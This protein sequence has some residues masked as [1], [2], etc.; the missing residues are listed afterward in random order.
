MDS[1]FLYTLITATG[2]IYFDAPRNLTIKG[3]LFSAYTTATGLGDYLEL[4]LSGASTNQTAVN[5]ALG[6]LA[7]ASFGTSG[8]G[9]PANALPVSLN[10]YC[11]CDAPIRA[12]ERV[13]LNYT[14]S[15]SGSWRTR[16]LVWFT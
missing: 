2:Q 6:V 13:Y 4:E 9:T 16:V 3:V 1:R 15:G 10:H 5:D 12:G 8:S 7:I 14:E 11:P